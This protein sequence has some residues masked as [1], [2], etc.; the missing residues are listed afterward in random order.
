MKAK[1]LIKFNIK[2][3]K[4]MIGD[5]DDDDAIPRFGFRQK[6]IFKNI[7][8]FIERLRLALIPYRNDDDDGKNSINS[9]N[10]LYTN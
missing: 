9:V 1:Q 10:C 2:Y 6:Y 5:D 3:I 8:A 4:C 7:I